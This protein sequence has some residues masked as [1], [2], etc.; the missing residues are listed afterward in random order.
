MRSKIQCVFLGILLAGIP[1][2]EAKEGFGMWIAKKVSS[3]VRVSPPAVPLMG[4]RIQVK[5]SNSGAGDSGLSER[6][7]RQ[8]ESELISRDN[9]LAVEAS[10]PDTLIEASI[11]QNDR[12][13]RWEDRQ[14]TEVVQVGKD[15]KGKPVFENRRVTVRYKVVTH[16]FALSYKVSDRNKGLSLD[17]DSLHFDFKKDFRDGKDAPEIFTLEGDALT[18]SVEAISR[19]ITPTR[20]KIGVLIP[21]GSLEDLAN[22]ALVGQWNLYLEALERRSPG[23]TPVDDSYRQYALGVAYEALGYAAD[24]PAETLKYLEQA[25]TYYNKAL[26]FNP[27]EKYFTQSYD[28]VLS[29]KKA[30]APLERVQTALANYRKIKDFKDQYATMQAVARQEET[31]GSKGVGGKAEMTNAAVI[32][33]ARAG[34]PNEVILTA[35]DNAE[36]PEFDASPRGLIALSEA[37]VDKKII[38]RIQEVAA[39]KRAPAPAAD[40][41]RK[42]TTAKRPAARKPANG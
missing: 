2:A 12:N 17:A 29:S 35:I 28:S 21:K 34:L 42:K 24:E 1:A 31:A 3:V 18:R 13:E 22:L 26:E 27:G 14:E 30:A 32:K 33:M 36:G 40:G 10:H 20:E 5:V 16:A 25:S 15:G 19:R 23:S 6:L 41:A 38:Q 9:R 39:G 7:E 11:L 4:T 37:Q 8:L